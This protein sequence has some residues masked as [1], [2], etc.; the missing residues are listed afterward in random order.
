MLHLFRR[1]RL[2]QAPIVARSLGALLV[3]ILAT[4]LVSSSAVFQ[5]QC[6][7][8]DRPSSQPSRRLR[9]MS[10]GGE[11]CPAE[12]EPCSLPPYG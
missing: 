3:L 9:S 2:P 12:R 11:G 5:G 10:D 8:L 7:P 4:W 6:L 1:F